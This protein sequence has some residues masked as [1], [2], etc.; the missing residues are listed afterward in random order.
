MDPKIYNTSLNIIKKLQDCG[1]SAYVVGGTVRDVLLEDSDKSIIS[2][3]DVDIATSAK[4]TQINSLFK[5]TYNIGAAF[6]I[7]NVVENGISFEVATF[8]EEA[9]YTDGRR[10]DSVK[11]TDSPKRD[12]KRR[13]FTINALFYDPFKDE[14]LDFVDGQ[15]D[16]KK[17]ILR[18]IGLPEK[19]FS[20]DYLR[21]LRA[22]RFGVRFDFEIDK[23]IIKAIKKLAPK[24]NELSHE[25]IRDE[26]NR[27]LTGPKPE[28]ALQLLS[29]MGILAIV[30]PEI[31]AMKGVS[32][33]KL[34][35]PEGDV[36]EHTAL[37]LNS[38]V[39]PHT[40]QEH[41]RA[42][43]FALSSEQKTITRP[44]K[45]Q[46]TFG[47]ELAW[48]VLLHDVGKPI[49]FKVDENNIER[50]IFHADK[51]ALLAKKI[52]QRLK[53]PNT[54]IARI[55]FAIKNHMRFSTAKEMRTAKLKRLIA[56]PTFPLELELH[57]LDCFCSNKLTDNFIFLLD[58][59]FEQ[60]GETKLPFPLI[61]GQDLIALGFTPGPKFG[62]I[63]KT[64]EEKQIEKELS[65][66][67]SAINWIKKNIPA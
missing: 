1:F 65:S 5:E 57:R 47:I 14:I 64:I 6:G 15:N 21:M 63:L 41:L 59:I 42:K 25:R 67:E 27:I 17:G 52:L 51:G 20:E 50:F 43:Q 45:Q 46:N 61:T 26:L 44:D 31:E 36:F 49:T 58:V 29:D 8:R 35:H 39:L 33:P 54:S 13:D 60:K 23:A 66:K 18:T 30:L 9:D 7:V 48:T 32:Q 56:E 12:A 53:F 19:R 34:Y 55:C 22:I 62:K 37:M 10:P 28:K 40:S 3:N 24:L 38:M 4:P 2:G 11:Y 16:L